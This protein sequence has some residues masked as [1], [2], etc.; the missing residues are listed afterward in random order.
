MHPS[1]FKRVFEPKHKE[2]KINANIKFSLGELGLHEMKESHNEFIEYLENLDSTIREVLARHKTLIKGRYLSATQH[3]EKVK[4]NVVGYEEKM[5]KLQSELDDNESI[6]NTLIQIANFESFYTILQDKLSE[7]E[8]A[9]QSK[10]DETMAL[11]ER[12]R[13][14]KILLLTVHQE[15]IKLSTKIIS[16]KKSFPQSKQITDE[17]ERKL[18]TEST[19]VNTAT[20]NLRRIQK[21][22]TS[23]KYEMENLISETHANKAELAKKCNQF[24]QTK[25]LF[26]E[27]SKLFHKNLLLTQQVTNKTGL[28]NSL[29][30]KINKNPYIKA[31]LSK[32]L[33]KF[34]QSEK[35]FSQDREIKNVVYSTLQK[36][37]QDRKTKKKNEFAELDLPW[38]EFKVFSPLQIM[39]LLSM[40]HQIRDNLFEEFEK[41][42]KKLNEHLNKIKVI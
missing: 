21:E 17:N 31:E 13:E 36:V 29:L 9:I 34:K 18:K 27:A 10:E 12:M 24:F 2:P 11:L 22:F 26:Y 20:L 3:L 23:I 32:T 37:V 39:G 40:N 38:E 5:L 6:K 7:L 25:N 42:E 28:K 19:V 15:N 16:I 4:K 30:F 8:G 1:S 41:K 33:D 35:P 14:K